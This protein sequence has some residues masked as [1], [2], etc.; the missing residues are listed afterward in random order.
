MNFLRRHWYDL[1]AVF[2]LILIGY[3]FFNYQLMTNYQIVMW[4]SLITLFFHQLEEY[5]VVGTFPGMINS[6][7]FKSETPDRF[8]L[9][10][11]T[12]FYINVFL[13][14][15]V[16]FLAAIFAEKAIWLGIT[17]ILVS[18]G[19]T[20]AHTFLFNIK[21]KTFYNAGMITTWVFFMPVI[22]F[23]FYI[24]HSEDLATAKDY[25]IGIPLGVI[26]NYVGVLKMIEWLS[27]KNT[28]YIF[29]KRNML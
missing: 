2:A 6:V 20:I 1:G 9:N 19:N 26:L 21:G 24:I 22:Y 10:T 13:G 5:R 4:I 12:S 16:Y 17:S 7:M 8:P 11:N 28:H 23:F 3:V 29:E 15:G 18:V 27:D 25:W 14:W